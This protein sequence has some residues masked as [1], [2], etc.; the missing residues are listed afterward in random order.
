M[1]G[2]RQ[3]SN[4]DISNWVVTGLGVNTSFLLGLNWRVLI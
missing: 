1:S 4:M 2:N 3:L